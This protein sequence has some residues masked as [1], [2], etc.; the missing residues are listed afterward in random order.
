MDSDSDYEFTTKPLQTLLEQLYEE[1][2]DTARALRKLRSFRNRNSPPL[3]QVR[4]LTRSAR[5]FLGMKEASL[6]DLIKLWIP[7]WKVSVNGR[8]LFLGDTPEVKFLGFEPRTTVDVYN[9]QA[10]MNMLFKS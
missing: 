3:T 1:L 10:H 8:Y 6:E 2:T 7:G 9:L 5:A 4:R